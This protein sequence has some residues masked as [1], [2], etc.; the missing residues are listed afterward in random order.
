V[1][2]REI[3]PA[4]LNRGSTKAAPGER[5]HTL[6]GRPRA[7]LPPIAAGE[8][9]FPRPPTRRPSQHPLTVSVHA[10]QLPDMLRGLQVICTDMEKMSEPLLGKI[11]ALVDDYAARKRWRHDERCRLGGAL[12]EL[13]SNAAARRDDECH[14]RRDDNERD[15]QKK[16]K[17]RTLDN[18]SRWG[19][20]DV[21]ENQK[22]D[23]DF[24]AL[25]KRTNADLV[26]QV[27]ADAAQ[28]VDTTDLLPVDIAQAL[29]NKGKDA[30]REYFRHQKQLKQLQKQKVADDIDR[31]ALLKQTHNAEAGAAAARGLPKRPRTGA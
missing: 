26:Q 6:Q 4:P 11:K 7:R 5:A 9:P 24:V 21:L 19:H 27:M 13:Q 15:M 8:A 10:S 2:T 1:V 29:L 18:A 23:A 30:K 14:R 16:L 3:K 17:Q 25:Q 20:H 22:P 31:A 12:V 28:H